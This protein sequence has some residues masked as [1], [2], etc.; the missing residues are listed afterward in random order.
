MNEFDV[1]I[2]LTIEILDTD[3]SASP[4]RRTLSWEDIGSIFPYSAESAAAQAPGDVH[5]PLLAV[6]EK[7]GMPPGRLQQLALI[8]PDGYSVVLENESL[9]AIESA[10][11]EMAHLRA[12]NPTPLPIVS[13]ISFPGLN[14]SH[15]V[16]SPC[17]IRATLRS[18]SS[19][20]SEMSLALAD[21]VRIL[22]AF[23]SDAERSSFTFSK[24]CSALDI[25]ICEFRVLASDGVSRTYFREIGLDNIAFSRSENGVWNMTG[26]HLP[27][28]M[29]MRN[30]VMMLI[31]LP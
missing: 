28:G 20:A 1:E 7:T 25:E 8:A 12:G 6:L 30:V 18:S 31:P 9:E 14:R 3:R 4:Q 26:D 19:G 21:A 16:T 29:R 15:T 17:R 10:R 27:R 23:Q 5:L 22:P 11:M 2:P 13:R 24:L